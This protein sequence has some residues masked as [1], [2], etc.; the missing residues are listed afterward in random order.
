MPLTE[1]D[2]VRIRE[3]VQLAIQDEEK[4]VPPMIKRFIAGHEEACPHGK[5]LARAKWVLIG[6]CVGA[7]LVGGGSGFAIAR[8]L[9]R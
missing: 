8:V 9:L 4:G 2:L 3:V 5:W 7:I 1:N 6:V